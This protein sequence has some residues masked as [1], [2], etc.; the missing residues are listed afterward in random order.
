MARPSNKDNLPPHDHGRGRE[1][2]ELLRQQLDECRRREVELRETEQHFERLV[3][4]MNE[5]LAMQDEDKHLTYVNRAFCRMLGYTREELLGMHADDVINAEGKK[6]YEF[7]IESRKRGSDAPYEVTF[8]RKDG[9]AMEAVIS[10]RPLIDDNG[11]FV[12]SFAVI[13]DVSAAHRAERQLRVEH[14]KLEDII[15]FL[16]DATFVVDSQGQVIAWNKAIEELTGVAKSE[17]LGQGDYAYAVP[18]YGERRPIL[19]DLVRGCGEGVDELYES[20]Q[21]HNSTLIVEKYVARANKGRGAYFWATASP[22]YDEQGAIVGAIE[23]IRDITN[24]KLDEQALQ[25]ERDLLSRVMETSPVGIILGNGSGVVT[26]ANA[27]AEQILGISRN[28]LQGR[29]CREVWNIV[30]DD[31]TLLP[32]EQQLFS[33]V[34]PADQVVYD[35]RLH[36]RRPDG[37]DRV[38]SLNFAPLFDSS[39]KYDGA[40]STFEDVTWRVETERA[41]RQREED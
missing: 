32:G 36:I 22:L 23:S 28:E 10:P 12:G 40:V 19:V 31:S 20:V 17:M 3:E 9:S 27:R 4:T 11:V 16:P 38:V 24:H 15:E 29:G 26:F 8:V 7:Q 18:L 39:G 2:F 1:Q 21:R 25:R 5:G 37:E 33:S 35:R 34:A 30:G 6:I 13:T 14:R 41:L